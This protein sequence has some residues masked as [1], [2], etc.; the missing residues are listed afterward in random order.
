[1]LYENRCA[2]ECVL[3]NF[4]FNLEDVQSEIDAVRC[5]RMRE[6]ALNEIDWLDAK[7][8]EELVLMWE[9]VAEHPANYIDNQLFKNENNLELYFYNDNGKS[10]D[11]QIEIYGILSKHAKDLSEKC[12]KTFGDKIDLTEDDFRDYFAENLTIYL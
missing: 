7:E 9:D 10:Q 12:E 3:E 8:C 2:V 11:W 6:Q 1:M 5:N 4:A